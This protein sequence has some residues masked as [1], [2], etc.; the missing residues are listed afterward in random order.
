M[1]DELPYVYTLHIITSHLAIAIA[2]PIHAYHNDLPPTARGH[3]AVEHRHSVAIDY[4]AGR[5]FVTSTLPLP[6]IPGPLR[7]GFAATLPKMHPSTLARST[8]ATP[9][10]ARRLQLGLVP[11]QSLPCP[12]AE[13]LSIRRRACVCPG[14]MPLVS[15][16]H[17]RCGTALYCSCPS[18]FS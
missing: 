13:S 10:R 4:M 8:Q 15:D 11:V 3:R 12:I 18:S 14:V 6:L 17:Q 5:H 2:T 16:P 7:F 9:V 1:A